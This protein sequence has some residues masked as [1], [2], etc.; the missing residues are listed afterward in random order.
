MQKRNRWIMLIKELR[1]QHNTS[2]LEA[3]RI[4]ISDPQWRRWV[5][6]Q[7]NTDVRCRRMALYHIRQN[8]D[9]ALIETEGD[10]LRLR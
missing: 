7:I 4:A 1:Q 6:L 9:T 2:I 5:E 3:E 8:G 10:R